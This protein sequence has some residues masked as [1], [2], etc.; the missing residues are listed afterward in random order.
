MSSENVLHKETIMCF[1][2]TYVI[3][4]LV[5]HSRT[6]RVYSIVFN[7]HFVG[8]V[9]QDIDLHAILVHVLHF[10]MNFECVVF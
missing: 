6:L 8:Y 7:I 9:H 10:I 5:Q 2:I 3:M 1:V 4:D